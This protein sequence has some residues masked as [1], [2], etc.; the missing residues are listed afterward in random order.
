MKNIDVKKLF[1]KALPFILFFWLFGKAGQAFRLAQC[2]DLSGKLLN[3]G[4]GFS[5]AFQNPLPSFHPQDLLVGVVG[6][7]IIA[8]ALNSKR[9]N[10]KKYRKDI[11][12]GSARWGN[13]SDIAPYV[14]PKP[15]SNIILTAMES[16]TLNG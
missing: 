6:A 5:A 2:V 12:Y 8:L 16:L 15:D 7:A 14:D 1:I 13:K 9:S 4:G 10:Q 3:L 11:E